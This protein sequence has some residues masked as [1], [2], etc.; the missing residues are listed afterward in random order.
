V[1][2]GDLKELYYDMGDFDTLIHEIREDI[3]FQKGLIVK[4][5]SGKKIQETELISQVWTL[6][7]NT[8]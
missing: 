5:S 3:E 1:L 2:H 8:F 7:R 4:L 6:D